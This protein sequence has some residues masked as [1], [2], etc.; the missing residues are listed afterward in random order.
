[1]AI[2]KSRLITQ[3][4]AE[5]KAAITDLRASD[6]SAEWG[7]QIRNYVLHPYTKVK[8][9]RTGAETADASAV[10]DGKLDLFIDAYLADQ[11]GQS[12]P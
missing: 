12:T 5:H 9:V 7:S 10:L 4:E 1:M 8:D 6:K 3:L 2:L 11:I